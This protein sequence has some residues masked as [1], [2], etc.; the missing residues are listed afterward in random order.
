MHALSVRSWQVNFS[1]Q[2]TAVSFFSLLSS[3]SL[4]AW[5]LMSRYQRVASA[6]YQFMRDGLDMMGG[7]DG[8]AIDRLLNDYLLSE[9]EV[10]DG[11]PVGSK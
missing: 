7:A 10:G 5:F 3:H 4:S 6:F 11:L 9:E 2:G 8:E 1:C